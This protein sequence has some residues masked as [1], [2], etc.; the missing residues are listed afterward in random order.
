MDVQNR[1]RLPRTLCTYEYVRVNRMLVQRTPV[2]EF[3]RDWRWNRF[4][5]HVTTAF[6]VFEERDFAIEP[7]PPGR[8]VNPILL[9]YLSLSFLSF[10]LFF[11]FAEK[12]AC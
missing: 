3:I 8:S 5:N 10:S 9:R 4:V 12:T 6:R 1:Q 7:N 11:S 2:V